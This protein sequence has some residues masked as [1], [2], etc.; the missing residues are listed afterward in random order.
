[1]QF[2]AVL[3]QSSRSHVTEHKESKAYVNP[4]VIQNYRPGDVAATMSSIKFKLSV[5]WY[6][7][8]FAVQP[9]KLNSQVT[10]AVG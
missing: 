2:P 1:M 5:V 4:F 9:R 3:L 6:S 7:G 10:G 8:E